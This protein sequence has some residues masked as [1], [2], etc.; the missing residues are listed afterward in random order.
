MDDFDS[1]VTALEGWFE[2]QLCDLPDELRQRTQRDLFPMTW[3]E[4]YPDQRRSIA[5][6]WDCLYNPAMEQDQR[7][8]WDYFERRNAIKQKVNEWTAAATPAATDLAQTE[9]RLA[10]LEKELAS[11]ELPL[12]IAYPKALK[13]LADRHKATPSE[14]AAWV[15]MG[16]K[17]G[18]LAAYLNVNELDPPQRFDYALI[19]TNDFDYLSPLMSCWFHA[20]DIANFQPGD[21]FIT[22]EALIERWREQ[23]GIKPEAFIRA[24][25]AESRLLDTHPICGG[26]Q[27]SFPDDKPYPTLASGLFMLSHVEKIEAEDFFSDL[28]SLDEELGE[29]LPK[30]DNSYPHG[31]NRECKEA[32]GENADIHNVESLSGNEDFGSSENELSSAFDP[33]PLSGIAKMFPIDKTDE[34]HS[35]DKWRVYAESASRNG[36]GKARVS[37][38]RGKA[39]STFDPWQVAEWLVEKGHYARDKADR[40]LANNLPPRSVHL[41][42]IFLL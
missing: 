12:F 41:K 40:K 25:I 35:L 20:N 24:K 10:E 29:H 30:D 22:G 18:G 19:D 23:P 2:K 14:I 42:D 26:T 7:S 11:M 32:E 27:G 3:D 39:K 16:P 34:Q 6:Q 4:L 17:Q 8:H 36:L 38:G 9:T 31:Q 33:L 13:L 37:V 5:H 15:W 21:R 28:S 1:L